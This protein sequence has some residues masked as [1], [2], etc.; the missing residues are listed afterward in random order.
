MQPRLD[1]PMELKINPETLL[2]IEKVVNLA[3]FK[4]SLCIGFLQSKF[5]YRTMSLLKTQREKRNLTQEELAEK[6]GV[7]VRTIQR[8]ESGIEP[9][10]Q[11]LKLL[12]EALNVH[13]KLLKYPEKEPPAINYTL[14]KIINLSS[15]PLSVLPPFNIFVPVFIMFLGKQFNDLTKQ[16]ISLQIIWTLLSFVIFMLSAFSKTWFSLHKNVVLIVMIILVFTN[17]TMILINAYSIDRDEKAL[18]RLN[19]SLI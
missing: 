3:Y 4:I 12:A 19:F 1:I 6:S 13:E 11:T 17:V 7:S 8:I 5:R 9:K 15:L 14:I 18:I 2:K 16:L 10:G